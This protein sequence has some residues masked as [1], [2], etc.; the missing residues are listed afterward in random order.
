[1]RK[2]L[3][4]I[5]VLVASLTALGQPTPV[6][7]TFQANSKKYSMEHFVEGEDATSGY[8]YLF[9]KSGPRIVMIRS[10]GSS[11]VNKT[12]RVD[13]IFF[14]RGLELFRRATG[15]KKYLRVLV[16]GKNAP[17][18]TTEEFHFSGERMTRWLVRGVEVPKTDPKWNE[19]EKAI[20][21]NAK[22]ELENYD[23]LKSG[24]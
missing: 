12:L 8:D 4:L 9:Y 19:T 6:E 10:I 11:S 5:T 13:D 7:K 18:I 22:S 20:L 24:K 17:L 16:K 23:W 15:P 14:G 1:M 21:E 3:I 2:L